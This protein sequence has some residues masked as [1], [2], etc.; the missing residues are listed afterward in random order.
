M[1]LTATRHGGDIRLRTTTLRGPT[2]ELY[3]VPN[4]EICQVRNFARG[5]FSEAT[6]QLAHCRGPTGGS[7]AAAGRC[8]RAFRSN[9]RL[10]LEQPR[11]VTA[12][13]VS[14]RHG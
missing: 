9:I 2:G 10:L 11:V 4:G 1:E 5:S 6:I 7:I 13:Q 8:G 14:G 3:F 12:D